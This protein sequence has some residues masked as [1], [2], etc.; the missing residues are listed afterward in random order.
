MP[1][2]YIYV[3]VVIGVNLQHIQS[4]RVILGARVRGK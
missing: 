4:T 2:Y 3:C 1:F